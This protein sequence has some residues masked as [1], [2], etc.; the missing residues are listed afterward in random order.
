MS[1]TSP[2]LWVS[3]IVSF[4]GISCLYTFLIFCHNLNQIR[5][6]LL[7]FLYL[8]V[9]GR[10]RFA[11]LWVWRWWI[12]LRVLWYMIFSIVFWWS[13]W[14][15]C[16]IGS[17][18]FVPTGVNSKCHVFAFVVFISKESSPKVVNSSKCFGGK[19]PYFTSKFQNQFCSYIHGLAFL[20]SFRLLS[21]HQKYDL[22]CSN[23]IHMLSF[24]SW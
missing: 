4:C 17:V 21:I 7:D 12:W 22:A 3:D 6:Y 18:V 19:I 2:V 20:L 23:G 8:A 16:W 9:I 15:C 1:L 14:S 10:I 5:S 11:R 24:E 13:C